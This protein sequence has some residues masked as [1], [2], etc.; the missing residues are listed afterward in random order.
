MWAAA[1]MARKTQSANLSRHLLAH[2][3]SDLGLFYVDGRKNVITRLHARRVA[4]S[5]E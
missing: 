3:N 2:A 5:P 1:A 4:N